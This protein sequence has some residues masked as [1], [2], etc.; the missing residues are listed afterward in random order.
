MEAEGRDYR[1]QS[2]EFEGESLL[3]PGKEEVNSGL[4]RGTR[5]RARNDHGR[6]LQ[7]AMGMRGLVGGISSS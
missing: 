3:V 2:S 6:A 5:L 1:Q 4:G 7:C